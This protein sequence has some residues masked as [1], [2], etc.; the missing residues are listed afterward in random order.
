K[1]GVRSL[2]IDSVPPAT[3]GI[4][5]LFSCSA[6]EV[7]LETDQLGKGHGVFFHCVL[8]G[9]R[10]KARNKRGEGTWPGLSSYVIERV[11]EEV[12]SLSP[13]TEQTPHEV[14][15]VVGTPLLLRPTPVVEAELAFQ[16]G[17]GLYL[18]RG[19]AID[20]PAAVRSFRAAAG[21]GHAPGRV[22]LGLCQ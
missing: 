4:A 18:G 13:G 12:A 20:Y 8:E 17:M 19:T 11:K 5:A 22:A 2:D 15:N 6:G 9:L 16:R 3:K 1:A 7:S 21:R 14:K 10:G